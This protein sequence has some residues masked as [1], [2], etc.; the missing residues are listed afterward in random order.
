MTLW[1]CWRAGSLTWT[2]RT[3]PTCRPCYAAAHQ[4]LSLLTWRRLGAP[5]TKSSNTPNTHIWECWACR[6]MISSPL[7][8]QSKNRNVSA[9]LRSDSPGEIPGGPKRDTQRDCS[10]HEGKL[11][12]NIQL[13]LTMYFRTLITTVPLCGRTRNIKPLGEQMVMAS[14]SS[15]LRN[16]IT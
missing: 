9:H 6:P 8:P 4:C 11:D 7:S 16:L 12:Y 10:A 2:T 15:A 1:A 5:H 13:V 3:S 14:P